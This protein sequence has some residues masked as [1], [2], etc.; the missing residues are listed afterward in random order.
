M[1]RW[2]KKQT[3][4]KKK[5][6]KNLKNQARDAIRVLR[7]QTDPFTFFFNSVIIVHLV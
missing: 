6:N 5:T 7:R 2:E 3:D 1:R 4:I